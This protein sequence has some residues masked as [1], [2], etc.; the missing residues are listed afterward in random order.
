MGKNHPESPDRLK[1]VNAAVRA[2][3]WATPLQI[4]QAPL[5]NVDHLTSVHPRHYVQSIAEQSPAEGTVALDADTTMNPYSLNAA[6]LAA[7]ASVNAT[8]RILNG[9]V[10]NAFCAVRPPGHHAESSIAMGFCLFNSV[11]L[12]AEQALASGLERV[13]ILDFDVHH[14]NGTVEIFQD[15]PEVLVCSSFQ[16]PFYPGRFDQVTKPNIVLSP[17]DANSGS[18]AFRQVIE[19]DWLPAIRNHQPQMIFVS[20]GFDAHAA[21]PLGGLLLHEQDYQWVGE[22]IVDWAAQYSDHRVMAVMEGGYNLEALASSAVRF[23][24]ALNA[25]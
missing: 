16:W 4:E 14:G 21:D 19:Q 11:A 3:K 15:K 24:N 10:R 17:L 7:G 2:A 8:K 23:I 5:L 12:A 20:A 1:A 22:H 18:D 13:A 6:L 25:S 9:E